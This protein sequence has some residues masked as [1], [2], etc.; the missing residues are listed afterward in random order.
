MEYTVMKCDCCGKTFFSKYYEGGYID[1]YIN[2]SKN[3]EEW[4]KFDNAIENFYEEIVFAGNRLRGKG[5][6]NER[7]DCFSKYCEKNNHNDLLISVKSAVQTQLDHLKE[8]DD[9]RSQIE[10]IT[11]SLSYGERIYVG[12]EG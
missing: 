7:L 3:F 4:V 1:H 9:I 12:L 10:K 8:L 2:F 6:I 11:D 5:R